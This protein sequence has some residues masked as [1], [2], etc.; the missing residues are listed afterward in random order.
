MENKPKV[1]S[2][3][4]PTGRIHLGN[5]WGALKNWIDIQDKYDCAFFVADWHALT[6]SSEDTASINS[7]SN[8]MVADWLA[9]G[10]DPEKC[11]IF[12]QS[13]VPQI[14][15]MSLLLGMITP[16]GWLLRNP[17]YKEQLVQLYSKKYAGQEHN[18]TH[19]TGKLA[20]A[21]ADTAEVHDEKEL[22]ALSEM[23]SYGFLGY[24][25]LMATDIL[26]NGGDL[27]PVGQDQL[28]HLEITRDIARRFADFYGK[29]ILKEP[30]PLL[31]AQPKVPGTD[32]RKMSK[33]YGNGIELMEEPAS[34]EKKVMGMFTDPGK[35][36]ANDKGNPDGCVVFSF[37]K[38]YNP[39]CAAREQ[40]C[41]AGSLGCVACKRHLHGLMKPWFEQFAQKRAELAK[42]PETVRTILDEGGRRARERA[43]I[44]LDSVRTAMK[45]R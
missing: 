37:H 36:R 20:Q 9:A 23:S 44:I 32:G 30:K 26:A 34:L 21:L 45:M 25:V 19:E 43:E 39:D 42:H 31:A 4:R 17:T 24:P 41:R 22:A 5:Y 33:S 2:G 13:D 16:L 38:L 29:G 11:I 28:A 27:V 12:R 1:I 35:K 14:A 18:T 10:L 40:E 15:E 3:M 7:N 6:T 8:E